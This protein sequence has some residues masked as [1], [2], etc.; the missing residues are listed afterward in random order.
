MVSVKRLEPNNAENHLKTFSNKTRFVG[1]TI[2][3]VIRE[4]VEG[5]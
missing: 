3:N 2:Y 1:F 4:S 5:G